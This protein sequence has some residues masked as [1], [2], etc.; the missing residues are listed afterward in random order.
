MKFSIFSFVLY[1]FMRCV[2]SLRYRL[3]IQGLKEVLPFLTRT[4]G[5]LI[6]P[7]HVAE[8]DPVILFVILWPYFHPRPIVVEDFYYLKGIQ[9]FLKTVK[10]LPCPN[11]EHTVN[12]W[13]M[14]SLKKLKEQIIEGL[15]VGEKYLIYP[16]GRLKLTPQEVLGGASFLPSIVFETLEQSVNP[17]IVLIRTEGLWGSRFSRALT[18]Q[19]PSFSAKF[20]EGVKIVLK[21]GLFFTPKRDVKIT[22]ELAPPQFFALK[23]RQAMNRYLETWYNAPNQGRGDELKLVPDFWWSKKVPTIHVETKE[24]TAE[25]NVNDF[26]EEKKKEI[27]DKLAELSDLS[28]QAIRLDQSLIR[29]LGL[30]SLD[31]AQ[32]TVFLDERFQNK[33]VSPTD[34]ERVEDL[35][36]FASEGSTRESLVAEGVKIHRLPKEN[37]RPLPMPHQGTT[38]QEAFLRSCDRMGAC[39]ACVDALSGALTYRR[40]KTAVFVLAKEIEKLPGEHIGILL[41]SSVGAYLSILAVLFAKKIPVMLNWTAGIKAM[42]HALEVAE[43]KVVLSSIKFLSRLKDLELGAAEEK[44]LLLEDLRRGIVWKDKI[45]G[46]AKGL[47]SADWLLNR[48]GFAAIKPQDCAVILF[49]SGTE[50]MPKGVPLSHENLLSNQKA[51]MEA[52]CFS[53][54]QDETLYGVLPPFHSFGFSVTGLLPLFAGIKV[55]YAPDPTDARRMAYDIAAFH[56][57]FFV[58]AP[59]FIRALFQAADRSQLKSLRLVVSGSEKMPEEFED[60][61]RSIGPDA[62]LIEGYGITECGPIVT[63]HRLGEQKI[64]VGRPL[65]DIELCLLDPESEAVLPKDKQGEIAIHGPNVFAGY[66]GIDTNPFLLLE[67]KRWYRSGDLGTIAPC[68]S[69]VLSGRLKRFVKIGA[70]MISLGGVEE[71]ILQIVKEKKLDRLPQGVTELK[72]PP[73]ALC[74]IE[75]PGEK[76]LLVLISVYELDK[77]TINIFLKHRGYSNLVRLSEIRFLKEIPLTGTGKTHYRLLEQSLV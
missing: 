63:M 41:P 45:R 75:K 13:K 65:K 55:I 8:M 1:W 29:D 27:F 3:H 33:G 52:V 74:A 16:S 70:E 15:K 71:E 47:F 68:G 37:S 72:G 50:T 44:I 32:L 14:R 67:G 4:Q 42:N 53:F 30:D 57:T 54:K 22:F 77:E 51:A 76:T 56:V 46:L 6:L 19:V 7:S 17:S 35:F 40:L 34:L 20:R 43:V 58:C 62:H 11:M 25:V 24:R 39:I 12:R 48:K 60:Y 2:V 28:S 5:A 36:R 21:N 9:S 61:V 38:L 69:L 26:P 23:D 10:A 73:I 49:T 31:I 59:S 66:L 18:G 64:G